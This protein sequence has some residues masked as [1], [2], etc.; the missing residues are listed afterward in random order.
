MHKNKIFVHFILC[1]LQKEPK[2]NRILWLFT[3]KFYKSDRLLYTI[4]LM[5][6]NISSTTTGFFIEID[7]SVKKVNCSG[8]LYYKNK[9]LNTKNRAQIIMIVIKRNAL[10][11]FSKSGRNKLTFRGIFSS[12]YK[13]CTICGA[14]A[15]RSSRE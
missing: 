1:K 8:Y 7:N 4:Y 12:S 14:L 15:R 5:A 13:S 10:P 9:F 3:T 2:Y 6:K 11:L